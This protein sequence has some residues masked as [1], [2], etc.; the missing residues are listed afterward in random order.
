LDRISQELALPLVL[1]HQLQ[2]YH[3]KLLRMIQQDGVY[4]IVQMAHLE[5]LQ[6]GSA[7]ILQ[8]NVHSDGA[9]IIILVV[10]V[11]A[12]AHS[13]GISMAITPP[14]YARIFA[15]QDHMQTTLQE[16]EYA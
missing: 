3:I 4:K 8:L 15:L 5:I 1:I 16:Q 9:H 10:L 2:V 6:Q 11:Y 14:I 13:H 7:T 12:L